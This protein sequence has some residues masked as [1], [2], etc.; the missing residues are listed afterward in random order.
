MVCMSQT[1]IL[2]AR[3]A[4]RRQGGG[5]LVMGSGSGR[6]TRVICA[7][8]RGATPRM[9]CADSKSGRTLCLHCGPQGRPK[10]TGPADCDRRVRWYFE[11]PP[12]LEAV[13]ET[14]LEFC[15]RLF[16]R[17]GVSAVWQVAPVGT[18]GSVT[19]C[20]AGAASPLGCQ[21]LIVRRC[22]VCLLQCFCLGSVLA[23]SGS[24]S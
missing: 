2:M 14:F 3:L 18:L 4:L 23:C 22:L 19:H 21:G 1:S 15:T 8:S 11:A 10:G 20:A 16:V 12:A 17:C 24:A 5:S 9:G 13:G 7:H 6:W